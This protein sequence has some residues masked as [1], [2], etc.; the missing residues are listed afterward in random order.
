MKE[1]PETEPK[2]DKM[3]AIIGRVGGGVFVLIIITVIA[4]IFIRWKKNKDQGKYYSNQSVMVYH[5]S[6]RALH[7]WW[8]PSALSLVKS[9]E[10]E[11][12]QIFLVDQIV[13]L[14]ILRDFHGLA[15]YI[16]NSNVGKRNISSQFIG[17]AKQSSKF[18]EKC[19]VSTSVSSSLYH[20]INFKEL[21]DS[22][23]SFSCCVAKR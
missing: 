13:V 11:K 14:E 21:D 19:S 23:R 18:P 16:I 8:Y 3:G 5:L 22:A 15:G 7:A 2:P 4:V 9:L 20:S 10:I 1:K 12:H 6:I 17:V